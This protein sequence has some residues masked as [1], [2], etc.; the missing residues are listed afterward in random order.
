M[1]SRLAW[2]YKRIVLSATVFAHSGKP[3]GALLYGILNS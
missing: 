2:R 3:V 1:T